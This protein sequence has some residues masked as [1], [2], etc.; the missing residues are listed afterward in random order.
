[1]SLSGN[2]V[3]C[4]RRS[5]TYFRAYQPKPHP[6]TLLIPS[7]SHALP[8]SSHPH[9]TLIP[10]SAMT[11]A[12][13]PKMQY[14]RL[15][16]TGLRMFT[17]GLGRARQVSRICLG[18]MSYGSSNW[19]SWVL[20]EEES[21][22]LIKKAYDAGINF[23]DT[24]NAYS[25]GESERILG[26]AIKKF[27]LP[28]EKIVVATKVNFFVH[29]TA[30][31][32]FKSFGMTRDQLERDHGFVNQQGLS[33][34]HIFESVE[35]SLSRLGLDYIDLYQIH[36]FDKDTPVEETMGALNDLVR[37]GKI[38]YIGASSMWAWQFAKLQNVAEKH[39]WTKFVS[40]QN[41]YNL[42]YREEERE[43]NPYCLDSG[44]GL[45]PW[46]P[47]AG[48]RLTAKNRNTERSK[49]QEQLSDIDANIVDRVSELAEKKGV[50]PSQ[51]ALAWLF[52]KPA[53]SAP[54]VGIG[55]EKYLVDAVQSLEVKLDEAEIKYLEEPYQPK[56]IYGHN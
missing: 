30:D 7:S 41:C 18:C 43:M 54:I 52:T 26:K 29:P 19:A 38:R 35:A 3:K 55:K 11:S 17:D 14:V 50:T 40:Q 31:M 37:M 8:S 24:A 12:V 25:F 20:D 53:V 46:A 56:A 51:I 33:R 39:G 21:L 10:S 49:N 1:R 9:P 48:G 34:K 27:N 22:G 23:F 6:L 5:G 15:G 45:I 28:R 36:R 4:F 42:L 47:I 32:S 2:R 13:L 44:V 16:T